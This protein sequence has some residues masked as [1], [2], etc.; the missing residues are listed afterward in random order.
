MNSED[1]LNT[2]HIGRSQRIMN[3]DKD[4][5]VVWDTLNPSYVDSDYYG[6][7]GD[8]EI[9]RSVTHLKPVYHPE[10]LKSIFEAKLNE[11]KPALKN[12]KDEEKLLYA[13]ER[14]WK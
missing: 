5:L 3:H 10:C 11:L 2:E 1:K 7:D 9:K 13:L 8:S 14:L 6:D 12:S 4:D